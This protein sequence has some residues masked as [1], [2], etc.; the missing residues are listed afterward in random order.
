MRYRPRIDWMNKKIL[1]V[2]IETMEDV[3]NV[4]GKR[5]AIKVDD[6]AKN[7]NAPTSTNKPALKDLKVNNE[8]NS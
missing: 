4:Y 5:T 2:N 1:G 3:V 6:Q 8:T 7:A